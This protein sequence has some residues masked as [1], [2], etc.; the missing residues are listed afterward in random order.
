MLDLGMPTPITG[1]ST[2]HSLWSYGQPLGVQCKDCGHCAL[3]FKGQIDDLKGDMREIAR[4]KLVCRKC[5][6][7][8]WSGWLLLNDA[9]AE[10]F[11]EKP[12]RGPTF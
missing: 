3:A 7:R 6:S 1:R 2:L 10:S 11:T 12:E 8:N 5:G 4:L 9:E